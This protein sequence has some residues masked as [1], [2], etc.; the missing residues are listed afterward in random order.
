MG[1]YLPAELGT[2]DERRVYKLDL[3]ERTSEEAADK[4]TRYLSFQRTVS[5][6]AIDDARRDYRDR[7]R[8][9]L[10][11]RTIPEAWT[12]LVEGEE[13]SLL[14]RLAVEVETKCGVKRKLTIS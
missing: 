10:A 2:Y 11:R 5:G 4:L 14:E 8:Q 13:P 3:Q 7:N 9:A 1:F 6:S 12:D